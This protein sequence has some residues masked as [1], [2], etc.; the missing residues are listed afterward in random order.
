MNQRKATSTRGR[1]TGQNIQE[2][3]VRMSTNISTRVTP[4]AGNPD[5]VGTGIA[6]RKM[7]MSIGVPSR[8]ISTGMTIATLMMNIAGHVSIGGNIAPV[9]NG[10]M[11]KGKIPVN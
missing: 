9:L 1:G 7:S 2:P 10:S 6:L 3:I 5:T 4:R 8:G 11:R